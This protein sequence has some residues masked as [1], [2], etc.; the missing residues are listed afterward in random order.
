MKLVHVRQREKRDKKIV[1][2][3]MDFFVS[4][5]RIQKMFDKKELQIKTS[6]VMP[7]YFNAVELC[8][9]I[10][11]EKPWTREMCKA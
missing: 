2:I 5:D 1:G 8:V 10:I 9:V 6:S 3:S 11:N 7:F 4:C